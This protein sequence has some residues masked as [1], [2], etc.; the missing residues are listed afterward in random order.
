MVL[1][2]KQ[3]LVT[4]NV[5]DSEQHAGTAM[6][7]TKQWKNPCFH[8]SWSI[9]SGTLSSC[10]QLFSRGQKKEKSKT[11]CARKLK[12]K[13]ETGTETGKETK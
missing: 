5:S 12:Q 13:Q 2:H 11:R 7:T 6:T 10:Q 1:E 4:L 3:F 9:V 8:R